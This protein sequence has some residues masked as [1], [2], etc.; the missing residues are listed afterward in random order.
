MAR[1]TLKHRTTVLAFAVA[2]A[3]LVAAPPCPAQMRVEVTPFVGAYLPG[4]GLSSDTVREG[5]IDT[6]Y[7]SG[8]TVRQTSALIGGAHLTAW[9]GKQIAVEIAGGFSPSGTVTRHYTCGGQVTEPFPSG[10]IV[11]DP[12]AAYVVMGSARLL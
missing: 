3:T 12:Q 8:A 2:S 5:G 10:C 9:L 6:Y 4:A 7:L 11:S 1:A